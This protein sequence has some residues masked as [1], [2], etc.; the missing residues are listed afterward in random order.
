ML[1]LHEIAALAGATAT[2]DESKITALAID[3]SFFMKVILFPLNS[4][5]RLT[6]DINDDSIY[7]SNLIGNSS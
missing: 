1:A 5:G 3:T 7:F 2:N 4:S 6:G